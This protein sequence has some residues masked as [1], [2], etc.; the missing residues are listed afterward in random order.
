MTDPDGREKFDKF[1][2]ELI[3]GKFEEHPIPKVLGKL[4]VPLPDSGLIYDYC[5]EVHMFFHRN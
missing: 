3:T 2:R 1:Y 5:F 4:E